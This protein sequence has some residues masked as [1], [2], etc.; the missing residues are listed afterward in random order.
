MHVRFRSEDVAYAK[1]RQSNFESLRK[2]NLF[3]SENLSRAFLK[4]RSGR[5]SFVDIVVHIR[6]NSNQPNV[7]A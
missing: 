2:L 7:L 6:R 3:H 1:A 5:Q 4:Q